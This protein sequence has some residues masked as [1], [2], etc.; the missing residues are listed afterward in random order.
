MVTF[1]SGSAVARYV[2]EHLIDA[3]AAAYVSA[4]RAAVDAVPGDLRVLWARALVGMASGPEEH[5][6]AAALVDDPPAGLTVDQ[7]MRWNVAVAAAAL[8]AESAD[9]RLQAERERDP[10]DRGDRAMVRAHAARPDPAVKEEVWE[11]IHGDGYDSLH[12]TMS[13]AAG[14]WRRRQREMLEP[15]VPRFFDGLPGLFDE[16]EQEAARGYFMNF[17]PG[18]RIDEDAR[19]AVAGLLDRDDLGSMLRRLLVE[20]EDALR[21]ALACRAFAAPPPEEEAPAPAD[22]GGGA[23][24]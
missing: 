1:T 22:D 3:E 19:S 2:P 6:V 9:A 16:W 20:R 14:F 21:R 17:F 7:E 18:Y 11:R 13:A 4:A 10:S 12:L 5:A 15:F 24:S 23:G 8:G